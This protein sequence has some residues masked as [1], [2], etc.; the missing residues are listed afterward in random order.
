MTENQTEKKSRKGQLAPFHTFDE[1]QT[2]KELGVDRT[3]GLSSEEV[4]QRLQKYGPNELE[5]EE[6]ES[7]W[8][9]IR[10]Q[11]EDLLVRLLLLAAVISFVVS[12]FGNIDSHQR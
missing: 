12:Q 3:K 8:E 1:A 2:L 4:H 5:K 11:F 6:G 10:E 7:I 9:K